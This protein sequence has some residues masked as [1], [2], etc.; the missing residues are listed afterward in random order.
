LERY[1]VL[2]IYRLFLFLEKERKV[3]K[4][5]ELITPVSCTEQGRWSPIR[6]NKNQRDQVIYIAH[7]EYAYTLKEIAEYLG[8]HYTT[9]SRAVKRTERK[10]KYDI[11]RPDP[12]DY[13][14]FKGLSGKKQTNILRFLG[15]YLFL[16]FFYFLSWF[17]SLIFMYKRNIKRRILENNISCIKNLRTH[18]FS[19]YSSH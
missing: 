1:R 10:V 16:L 18:S 3:K 2:R 4:K 11:A 7:L 17:L 19:L 13:L 9:V 12:K 8:I 15:I 6:Q 14:F 5:S